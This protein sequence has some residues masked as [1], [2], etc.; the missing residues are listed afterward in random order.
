MTADLTELVHVTGDA[1]VVVRTGDSVTIRYGDLVQLEGIMGPPGA[2]GPPGADGATGPPGPQGDPGPTGPTGPTGA[3]GATGPAGAGGLDIAT[4]DARYV[5]TW[6]DTMTDQLQFSGPAGG[7]AQGIHWNDA[8]IRIWL[9][10]WAGAM[11]FRSSD[12]LAPVPLVT[13]TLTA[14]GQR[15]PK[16]TVSSS[17]PSGGTDG[18]VWNQVV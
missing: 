6:G 17:A 5:N 10:F 1:T 8:G 11:G 7:A 13:G 16:V 9:S 12:T 4:A 2:T 15:V 18:D 14:E 3:T